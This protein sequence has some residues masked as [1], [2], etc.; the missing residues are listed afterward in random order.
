[1]REP[2]VLRGVP[3]VLVLVVVLLLILVVVL[4]WGLGKPGRVE[5]ASDGN[6][7]RFTRITRKIEDDDD[8]GR[9]R[10]GARYATGFPEMS[11]PFL[12]AGYDHR[13]F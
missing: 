1:M 13:K 10:A 4:A 2:T 6:F 9:G 11:R 3:L 8:E 12:G 5:E 7:P